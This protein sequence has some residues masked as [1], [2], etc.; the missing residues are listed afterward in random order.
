M[1]LRILLIHLLLCFQAAAAE[2]QW[3]VPVKSYISSETNG[4]PRAF[5][6]IPENCKKVRAVIVGQHN[7]QE[8]GIMEHPLFRKVMRETDI[9]EIWISPG[10][11]PLFNPATD[12]KILFEEILKPLAEIS[13][14][15]EL[16]FAPIIPLGHSAYATFPWTFA[17]WHP[18]RTLAVLSVHGDAPRTHLTGAGKPS[19]EWGDRTTRGI[20]GL[21]VMG[22]YEWWEE[23]LAPALA[24]KNMHPEAPVSFLADAGHGHF[25]HSDMLIEYLALFVK[26]AVHK[27]L[28]KNAPSNKLPILKAIIP[29]EGWLKDRWYPDQRLPEFP[30]DFYHRYKGDKKNAFWYFDKEM[31]QATEAYY[32]RARGKQ[33]RAIGFYVNKQNLLLNEN[34]HARYSATLT[35]SNGN[36]NF[37]VK[38]YF[39]DS[40]DASKIT[41]ERVCGPVKKLDDTTFQIDFYRMG[42]NNKKR[43]N[44]IWLIANHTGTDTF[45]SSVQQLNLKFTYPKTDGKSQKIV[46]KPISDQKRRTDSTPLYA[47]SDSKLPVSFYVKEGPAKIKNGQL[48]FTKIPPKSRMPVKVTVV[49]WQYGNDEFK[50]ADPV[51]QV[52][53]IEK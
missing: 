5:L 3:S 44:D 25:D 46:F 38:S 48:H 6:W 31:A 24:Y 15:S 2:W 52:F 23:R 30:A 28:P 50:S 13:G 4:E 10:L 18:E 34:S 53:V 12:S 43:T 29:E 7:M 33:N 41:I 49:A 20:P 37:T 16:E 35:T 8:E 26:K 32:A 36:L 14:Y 39:T 17:A 27:R 22:E 42:L 45:K 9:A 51:E 1:K 19:P 40:S 11:S 47:V 21:M